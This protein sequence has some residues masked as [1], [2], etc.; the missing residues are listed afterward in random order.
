MTVVRVPFDPEPVDDVARFDPDVIA[1]DYGEEP[2]PDV[3]RAGALRAVRADQ[4]LAEEIAAPAW[5]VDEIMTEHSIGI[6]GAAPKALKSTIVED[7]AVAIAWG[8]Q[9][10]ARFDCHAPRRVLLYQN[11]SSRAAFQ[12]RIAARSRRYGGAPAELYLVTNEPVLF[13]DRV[14]IGRLEVTLEQL[15]PDV[16]LLDPL[17]SMTSAD[18][19]SAQEVGAIVRQL[20]AWRDRFGCAIAVVHH[21]NKTSSGVGSGLRSGMKLRGSSALYAMI[22]WALWIDRPDEAAPRVEVRVE[23]KESE[24]RRPFVVELD[25]AGELRVVADEITVQVTDD[26]LLEAIVAH[27]RVATA[28]AIATELGMPE[29]TVRDRMAVLVSQRRAYI[30]EGSGRGRRPLEYAVPKGAAGPRLLS[31]RE[32]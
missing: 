27:K 30:V 7:L 2:P 18:E 11:E 4:F 31:E 25:R 26:E 15:R 12:R 24:P 28:S 21:T 8:G 3:P 29:R 1:R 20:R 10:L 13:E 9:F 14:S 6:V 5:I 23:Q 19:N 17:A 16:V 22:E 32:L